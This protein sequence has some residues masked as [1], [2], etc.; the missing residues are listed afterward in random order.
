MQEL[1]RTI[2][3]ICERPESDV[4]TIYQIDETA[5]G[6]IAEQPDAPYAGFPIKVEIRKKEEAEME[7]ESLSP[8]VDF[9]VA[10]RQKTSR[11]NLR[12][13]LR[14]GAVAAVIILMAVVLFQNIPTAKAVTL[15]RIYQ[16]IEKIRN[17]HITSFT[18][19][20]E[21]PAQELWI[22][23]TLNIY[24][25]KTAKQFVLWDIANKTKKTKQ[26]DVGITDTAGLP[27]DVIAGIE[28]I[29]SSASG[30]MP[31]HN[32]SDVPQD[33]E[34]S[35]V[36]DKSINAAKGIEV[37]DLTWSKKTHGGSVVFW[38]WRVFADSETSLPRK[39]EWYQKLA[40]DSEYTLNSA[41]DVEYL[42]EGE[43]RKAIKE[44]S[45]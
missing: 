37:Y 26:P 27:D 45:F 7:A 12:P 36:D 18:S 43:V 40:A 29:M 41:M 30:I 3:R 23:K 44:A 38:K 34:W 6:R 33:A 22:S 25:T 16:A 42:S 5:K 1:H 8:D 15:E 32:I 24:V 11:I 13:L 19:S 28:G 21:E 20:K 9:A 14:T 39:V 35:R 31:F 4:V 2:Y 17:V 10:L